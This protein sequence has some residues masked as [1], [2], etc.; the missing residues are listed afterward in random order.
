MKIKDKELLCRRI[1]YCGKNEYKKSSYVILFVYKNKESLS[2]GQ[3]KVC[4]GDELIWKTT[5]DSK[6][7]SIL[8][9]GRTY[10]L[11]WHQDGDMMSYVKQ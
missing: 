5:S 6:V 3:T 8:E 4:E 7:F 11:S 9:E 10:T 2:D 1:I